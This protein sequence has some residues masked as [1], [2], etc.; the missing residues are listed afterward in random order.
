MGQVRV[1]ISGWRYPAWRG[2]FYPPRL[3]QRRELE[4]AAQHLTSIEINGTF[5]S[6]QRPSSFQT[7]R[8]EVPDDFV[9]SVKGGRYITH[10]KRLQDP[11]ASL[12]NFFAS[13]VL[14]LGPKLGPIL[15]QLPPNFAF[16]AERI[17]AFCAELPRT[18]A[19]AARLAGEHDDKLKA[20]AWTEVE[21]D[22]PLRHA[23]EA[24]HASFADPEFAAILGEAGV[25]SVVSDGGTAWPAFE[26]LTTD[27]AYVRLHGADELYASGYDDEALRRWA[28]KVSDWAGRGDVVVYFDN[29]A[30]VRAPH[31]AQALIALL[32]GDQA[33]RSP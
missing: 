5:Y 13:G 1:G 31:D 7:W 2:T 14:A 17:A 4:Y 9:F 29:D 22:R 3:P 15:W 23:I 10:L 27:F 25:A 18:T 24:R 26:H 6:L 33:D 8:A 12:A 21:E 30:K 28:A 11:R 20:E 19:E 32:G 16:D